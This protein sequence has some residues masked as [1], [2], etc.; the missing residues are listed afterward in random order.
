M[1]SLVHA[2]REWTRVHPVSPYLGAGPIIGLAGLYA[3]YQV[4][5]GWLVGEDEGLEAVSQVPILILALVVVLVAAVVVGYSYIAWRRDEY[6]VGDDALYHRKGILFRQHRQARLD[7]IEAIDVVQPLLARIF[8]M[9]RLQVEVAGGSGSGISLDYLRLAD[10][11]AM[12][13]EMLALV[14]RAAA[15]K[16]AVPDAGVT[17]ADGDGLGVGD[18]GVGQESAGDGA[19]AEG[20]HD[21]A[22]APPRL[23]D[24]PA[25][26]LHRPSPAVAAAPE[27]DVYTVPAG[28]LVG[29]IVA[30]SATAVLVVMAIAAVVSAVTF[31]LNVVE[32]FLSAVGTSV[33]AIVG[34]IVGVLGYFWNRLNGGFGFTASISRDGLR[35]RHGLLETRK[36]TVTPGR[37]QAISLTQGLVWRRFGWWRV[38]MNVAGY[39]ADE[40][41]V[42]VLLPVGK[43][44]DA[45]LALWLVLPEVGDRDPG[46]E[47]ARALLGAGAEDGFTP[48]PQ[49][50]KVFDPLQ[51]RRR[52]VQITDSA[53][54]IRSGFFTH[55]LVVVPTQR[56]QSLS[57]V[58][59][60]WRRK[61]RLAD[62]S[63]HSTPGPVTAY[64]SHLD[65]A[66]AQRLLDELNSRQRERIARP[67]AAEWAQAVGADA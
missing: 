5:P 52:G 67:S 65:V 24:L 49:R 44:D 48:S 12:R 66:D 42:S 47:M 64:A 54:F 11:E 34:V 8:G 17:A 4:A 41:N 3:L 60:P 22:P 43:L 45:L 59:G 14:A 36:Q 56:M 13:N 16:G 2:P 31:Q 26:A 28:R 37:V 35:L 21:A 20:D 19:V 6:R 30:S 29:S 61:R 51:G 10:A 63:I 32:L 33:F 62:L 38:S 18:D 57:I 15:A 53:V 46:G 58:Q 25:D 7:R 55:R 23:R 9:A 50:A 1:T 40:Q 27:R 39:G